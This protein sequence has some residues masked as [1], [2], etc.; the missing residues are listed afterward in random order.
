MNFL[1]SELTTAASLTSPDPRIGEWIRLN[2]ASATYVPAEEKR[3]GYY[4][5]ASS[6]SSDES[7]RYFHQL[8]RVLQGSLKVLSESAKRI[9]RQL[10]AAILEFGPH[11]MGMSTVLDEDEEVSLVLT[12][13]WPS[14]TMHVEHFFNFPPDEPCD[15]TVNTYAE[16]TGTG[17]VPVRQW[18]LYC[19]ALDFKQCLRTELRSGKWPLQKA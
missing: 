11:Q 16:P 2:S 6:P 12:A 7:L 19:A 17:G 9:S 14:A 1:T 10:V 5:G 18:G 4:Y 8:D 3:V 13:Y 15:T